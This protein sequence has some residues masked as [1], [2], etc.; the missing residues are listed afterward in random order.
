[1][2]ARKTLETADQ[3]MEGQLQA[4]LLQLASHQ[5]RERELTSDLVS[6]KQALAHLQTEHR[7][8]VKT[9][10]TNQQELQ[11][12]NLQINLLQQERLQE[13]G[14]YTKQLRLERERYDAEL[15]R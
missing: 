6:T 15:A 7:H 9:F 2:L 3:L 13:S 14:T 11:Q 8:L 1:M 10:D 12:R 4:L 5:Q